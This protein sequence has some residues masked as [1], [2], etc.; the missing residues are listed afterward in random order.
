MTAPLVSVVIPCHNRRQYLGQTLRSVLDQDHE[1]IEII[2]MD[3][4]STD[5]TEALMEQ[6][7][8]VRYFRQEA[9]GVAVAR[10]RAS[11][12]ARGD[13]IAYQDD[14]D[15]MPADRIP[16]LLEALRVYPDAAFATGDYALIDANG[17]LTGRRWMPGGLD[18]VGPTRL[19]ENGHEAVLWPLVPAVPHTTLFRTELGAKIGWFDPAFRYACS[20]AD[21]LA[22]L[23]RLGPVAY[24]RKIMSYYRRGHSALWADDIRTSCSQVQLWEKHIGLLGPGDGRLRR[25]LQ[26]RL[27]G[28]LLRLEAYRQSRASTSFDLEDYLQR[29]L[30]LLP[31]QDRLVFELKARIKLPLRQL[32]KGAAI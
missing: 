1:N 19:I 28:V 6:F 26:E 21:F 24:V 2:L 23:G 25:R 30:R 5:G 18:E 9:Q 22:R 29:G 4:G 3:D 11:E 15:L 17:E 32:L 10:S 16:T 14:D 12:L 8:E 27:G 20:D 13:F 31:A 7:P